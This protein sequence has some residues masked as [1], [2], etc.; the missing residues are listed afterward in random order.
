MLH[1]LSI[2]LAKWKGC[3]NQVRT[4][5]LSPQMTQANGSLL[6]LFLYVDDML[7]ACNTLSAMENLKELFSSAFDIKDIGEGK[8]ILRM[9][10]LRD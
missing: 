10:I 4:R 3:M 6:Y 9:E 5:R 7:V 2:L 8:K 1:M